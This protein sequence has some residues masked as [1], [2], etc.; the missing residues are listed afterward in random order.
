MRRLLLLLGFLVACV[1]SPP[2]TVEVIQPMPGSFPAPVVDPIPLRIAYVYDASVD[3]AVSVTTSPYEAP[4]QLSV[5][6]MTRIAFDRTMP[7]LFMAAETT[8]AVEATDIAGSIAIRL[9]DAQYLR[10]GGMTVI[11]DLTFRAPSGSIDDI[12]QIKGTGPAS[13]EPS[14]A[15]ELAVRDAVGSVAAEMAER[16]VIRSWT[17]AAQRGPAA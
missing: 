12:W 8:G 1:P 2:P 17:A 4:R 14:K 13:G 9:L 16:P 7:V 15:L 5:G 10:D 3:A 6:P 11:Y